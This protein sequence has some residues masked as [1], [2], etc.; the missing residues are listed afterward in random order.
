M[1]TTLTYPVTTLKV[2]GVA[3]RELVDTSAGSSGISSSMTKLYPV[4]TDHKQIE[5]T[6]HAAT[7]KAKIYECELCSMEGLF[8]IQAEVSKV[9]KPELKSLL[10]SQY[11]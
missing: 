2:V 5:T 10:N 8:K 7:T 4:R 9:I 1:K 11:E 6:L 3:C